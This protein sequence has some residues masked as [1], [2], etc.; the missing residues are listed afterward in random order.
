MHY[1]MSLRHLV[2]A[3]LISLAFVTPSIAAE[4]APVQ[5]NMRAGLWEIT[6]TSGL[7]SLASEIPPEQMKNIGDLAKEYGFELPPIENGAAKTNT[8][9]T[10]EMASQQVLPTSFQS[11]AGCSVKHAARNGNSY[12]MEYVC[13]NAD[14]KGT[15]VADGVLTTAES[16]TGRTSFKGAVQG[17]VVNEDAEVKGKW[18]SVSCEAKP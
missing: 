6:T 8:C 7:L 18:L 9:I 16:F 10:P 13:D 17:N 15:G 5:L 11:Q 3:T 2:F 12:H 1:S 4:N 14:I